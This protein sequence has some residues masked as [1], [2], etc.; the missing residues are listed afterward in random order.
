MRHAKFPNAALSSNCNTN[1]VVRTIETVESLVINVEKGELA[2]N[3]KTFVQFSCR[4][5][6]L[7]I[8]VSTGREAYVLAGA[9]QCRPE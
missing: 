4:P 3:F 9:V 2:F 8:A 7:Y 6:D 1:T 5:G